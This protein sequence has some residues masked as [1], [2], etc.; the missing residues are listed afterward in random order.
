MCG[1]AGFCGNTSNNPT[2]IKIMC[3]K[4][5]TRGPNAEGYWFDE[6]TVTRLPLATPC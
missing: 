5:I 6:S 2:Q 1:I 4:I 3:D